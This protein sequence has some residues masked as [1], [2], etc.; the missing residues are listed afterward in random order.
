MFPKTIITIISILSI[1][2]QGKRGIR[3]SLNALLMKLHR[4]LEE[5]KKQVMYE[6]IAIFFISDNGTVTEGGAVSEFFEN[7][8]PFDQ[9]TNRLKGSVY[10]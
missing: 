10:G 8:N 9:A 5:L 3:C 2:R 6:N 1:S 4:M 7:V